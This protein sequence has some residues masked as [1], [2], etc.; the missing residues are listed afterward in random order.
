M[1]EV[2]LFGIQGRFGSTSC[3]K[4][5]DSIWKY[6]HRMSNVDQLSVDPSTRAVI[7]TPKY[8]IIIS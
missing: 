7:Y 4:Q 1:S 3:G 5:P 6:V 2:G 8:V